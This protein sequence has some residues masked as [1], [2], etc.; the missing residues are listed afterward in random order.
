MYLLNFHGF[1]QR[2]HSVVKCRSQAPA[3]CV[4][5]ASTLVV[6]ALISREFIQITSVVF[7]MSKLHC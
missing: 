2:Q 4:C 6:K 3:D 5:D 1:R 7:F